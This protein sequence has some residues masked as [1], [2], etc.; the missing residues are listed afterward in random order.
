[1]ATLHEVLASLPKRLAQRGK[2]NVDQ[3]VNRL[4]A[5]LPATDEPDERR[6][7]R[8]LSN[9][10]DLTKVSDPSGA[11]ELMD[12]VAEL[13][14]ES[15]KMRAVRAA[16]LDRL[17]RHA[18]AKAVTAALCADDTTEPETVLVA[19]NLLVRYNEQETALTAALGA[20]E[21]LGRPKRHTATVL[22]I[23]QRCAA[24][25]DSDRLTEEI[26]QAYLSDDLK[27]V[28]E[29]PRTNLLWSADEQMNIAVTQIWAG[30]NLKG[31]QQRFNGVRPPL[32]GRRLKIGYLSSD[33]R[34]HPTLRLMMGA[35]RH[36]DATRV[37]VVLICSGWDD[38]SALRKEAESL[39]SSV[40]SVSH[41]NDSDAAAAIKQ[42]GIDV[43]VE[44]NGPTRANRMSILPFRPAPVQ[45]DYLGWA[46]SVGG[47]GVDY[48]VGDSWTVPPGT[49]AAYPEAVM[50]MDPSYQ[51]NDHQSYPPVVP[52]TR[53]EV[54]LPEDVF[55]FGVF[56]AINKIQGDVW[57]V[58]MA[59][60]KHVPNSVLWLLDPG[61]A[62]RKRLARAA[63]AAGVP[64]S[65][66]IG[67]KA[68]NNEQHLRRIAVAD[69]MLDPW[70]Y[71]GHT[72]TSDALY[73]GVPVVTI[74]GRNFP[75]RV[76]AGLLRSAGLHAL[77][78]K[79]PQDYANKAARLALNP[80]QLR[81][82]TDSLKTVDSTPCFDAR[83]R[84]RQ[85]EALFT[86]A[87]QRWSAGK[88]ITPITVNAP[89][90]S[91]PPL[92]EG[93]T[94]TVPNAQVGYGSKPDWI[95]ENRP[96]QLR[97]EGPTDE[98]EATGAEAAGPP[99]ATPRSDS[100]SRR[101]IILVSGSWSSGTSATAQVV[102]ALGAA[103]P[104]DM[105]RVNDAKTETFEMAAFRQ[106]LLSLASEPKLQRKATRQQAV[107]A[108]SAFDQQMLADID[109]PIMLKHPLSAL[110]I[111]ELTEV[112]DCQIVTVVRD[113]DDV[114]R[115]R[116]RRKWS[117]YFGSKGAKII[118]LA[119]VNAIAKTDAPV[120][121]LKYRDLLEDTDKQVMTI[122]HFIGLD[123]DPTAIARAIATVR[124]SQ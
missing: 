42:E 62:A 19:A 95:R 15:S 31:D 117:Q 39:V 55:V 37:E 76:S 18:E 70:P 102:A 59:I 41:L 34:L 106:V 120:L 43:L 32:A 50:R 118:Y 64:V 40:L 6:R 44:L 101:R 35:L 107:A 17:G 119:L 11:L 1:M 103:T 9:A 72:S 30:I 52:Y 4:V 7:Y 13:G 25:A 121:W 61:D 20:Y 79:D 89:R 23:T 116:K 91:Q 53:E 85:L 60:L 82:V 112:F 84:T 122:A 81:Q 98:S 26:A 2:D 99:T 49:E 124:R 114:E 90:P 14:H 110:F 71:G 88:P 83:N 108:F 38:G 45:V 56:N 27:T 94:I 86:A 66:I 5:Q 75:G 65:R 8:L 104:G 80:D 68:M 109:G 73:A 29:S 47:V 93:L 74:N 77:V 78:A 24:F 16:C 111:D 105:F 123:G 54:G 33:F 22:Y 12:W 21:A 67:A 87:Y 69:L 100:A 51:I 57:R 36:H 10:I 48:V 46:G 92:T 63:I 58:W 97:L 113:F 3:L 28:N 96:P 115:T